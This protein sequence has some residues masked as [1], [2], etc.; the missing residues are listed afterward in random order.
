MAEP[1]P[2]RGPGPLVRALDR[3]VNSAVAVGQV[4]LGTYYLARRV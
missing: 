4:G 2:R 3:A 1:D